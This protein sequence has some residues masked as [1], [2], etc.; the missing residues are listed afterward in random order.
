[1]VQGAGC[2]VQG[3]GC[4]VQGSGFRIQGS[5]LRVQGSGVRGPLVAPQLAGNK[6][7]R[8]REGVCCFLNADSRS[9]RT[10]ADSDHVDVSILLAFLGVMSLTITPCS[11]H[12]LM[13]FVWLG[14][15]L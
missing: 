4:R 7:T 9:V 2:R 1:M 11:W 14:Y 12:P 10:I 13:G 3:A 6:S 5:G 8:M 15:P